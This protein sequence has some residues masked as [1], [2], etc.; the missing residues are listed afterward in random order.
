MSLGLIQR[1][2]SQENALTVKHTVIKIQISWTLFF[3]SRILRAKTVC[4]RFI[5][6]H[7]NK[8]ALNTNMCCLGN[9]VKCTKLCRPLSVF[10]LQ[11]FNYIVHDHCTCVITAKRCKLHSL[12]GPLLPIYLNMHI[13]KVRTKPY[14]KCTNQ[15]Q[16]CWNK[17]SDRAY[18]LDGKVVH[19]Y[20]VSEANAA[21]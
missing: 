19:K 13:R 8:T 11:M 3:F 21:W 2:F 14:L 4:V 12:A 9:M 10:S 16:V 20:V 6:N 15:C 5:C 17:I 7:V 18:E 1:S